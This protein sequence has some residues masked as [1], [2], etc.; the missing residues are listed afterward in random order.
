MRRD[1]RPQR[2]SCRRMLTLLPTKQPLIM[3]FTK[4]TPSKNDRCA[5]RSAVISPAY[6]E[7]LP[8]PRKPSIP[9]DKEKQT[10][11]EFLQSVRNVLCLVVFRCRVLIFITVWYNYKLQTL[12]FAGSYPL[13]SCKRSFA[14][15]RRLPPIPTFATKLLPAA[16]QRS[17]LMRYPRERL[18]ASRALLHLAFLRPPSPTAASQRAHAAASGAF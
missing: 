3:I 18:L 17:S 2:L 9:H 16:K 10:E 12:S 8:D 6:L 15:K 13:P 14:A 1:R 7:A 11:S 5:Q 4:P